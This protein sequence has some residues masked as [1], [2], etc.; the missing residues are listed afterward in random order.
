MIKGFYSPWNKNKTLLWTKQ[1]NNEIENSLKIKIARDLK[2][3]LRA[4]R[5]T[6]EKCLFH[7]GD[8]LLLLKQIITVLFR[9]ESRNALYTG[10]EVLLYSTPKYDGWIILSVYSY[11]T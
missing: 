7:I 6:D 1:N 9:V 8:Y 3:K 10:N 5:N 11:S 2:E 4:T